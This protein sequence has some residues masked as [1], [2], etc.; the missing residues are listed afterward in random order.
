V[1]SIH[2]RIKVKFGDFD[3]SSNLIKEIIKN[4]VIL[5]GVEEFY[6]KTKFFE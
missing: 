2:S 3:L 1:E 4:H 5:K 6:E